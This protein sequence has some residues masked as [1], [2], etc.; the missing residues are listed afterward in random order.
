MKGSTRN[1]PAAP[2]MHR[3]TGL[4]HPARLGPAE[5]GR[6]H[7]GRSERFGRHAHQPALA[8]THSRKP[9]RSGSRASPVPRPRWSTTHEYPPRERSTTLATVDIHGETPHPS[10]NHDPGKGTRT[11]PRR[12]RAGT[13]RHKPPPTQTVRRLSSSTTLFVIITGPRVGN[14]PEWSPVT[15]T[16]PDGQ[17]LWTRGGSS[18]TDRMDKGHPSGERELQGECVHRGVRSVEAVLAEVAGSLRRQP[19]QYSHLWLWES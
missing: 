11:T 8:P 4:V 1:G 7:P 19:G 17:E 12:A 14:E 3:L 9:A 6:H 13:G 18:L 10:P 2:P 16:G 5:K 15:L